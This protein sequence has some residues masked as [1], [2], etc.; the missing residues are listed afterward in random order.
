MV[1]GAGIIFY[2]NI[3]N[4]ISPTLLKGVVLAIMLLLVSSCSEYL[5]TSMGPLEGTVVEILDNWHEVAQTEIIQFETIGDKGQYSVNLWIALVEGS[6]Y[7][8]AGDNHTEWVQNIES[9][10][11]VRL[12]V[13]GEIFELRAS[14]VVDPATFEQFAQVWESK[15]GNRPRNENVQETYLLRLQPRT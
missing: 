5:P 1:N 7:V 12:G 14:R 3:L 6:L 11:D 13:K 4:Q 2:P 15:Y 10:P 8:F 9:N